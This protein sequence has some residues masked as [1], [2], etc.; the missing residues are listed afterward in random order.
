M[1]LLTW[2]RILSKGR[3]F[4]RDED[5]KPY[6]PGDYLTE[7]VKDAVVFYFVKKDRSL[8][9]AVRR[10]LT[11]GKLEMEALA[12]RVYGMVFERVFRI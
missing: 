3:A 1:F 12:E 5:G 4:P 2:T 8:E 7:A 10:Y 9:A 6:V 11:G